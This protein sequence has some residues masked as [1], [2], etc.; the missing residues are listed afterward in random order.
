[1]LLKLQNLSIARDDHPVVTDISLSIDAGEVHVL[2]GKNG[3][4]KSTLFSAIMGRPGFAVTK[5]SV[6][7]GDENIATMPV[8]ERARKGLFLGLQ[9]PPEISGITTAEFLRTSL[10]ARSSEPISSK[11]FDD[12]LREA[13]A[14]L[15]IDP[16]MLSRS[17]NEGFSGG[18]KKRSEMLQ[19]LVLRPSIV[20]LDEPDSGLDATALAHAAQAID[21][22]RSA[23]T[24]FLIV[25]HSAEFLRLLKPNTLHVMEAGKMTKSGTAD[26][27]GNNIAS[28]LQ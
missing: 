10:D 28:L 11:V 24:G 2:V 17:L 23:G 3:A 7:L 14:V 9:Q 16:N 1:M 5:G 22:L 6:T 13:A 19:M 20:L 4:G 26:E 15:R 8:H 18:E 25:T 27:L 12:R 21:V